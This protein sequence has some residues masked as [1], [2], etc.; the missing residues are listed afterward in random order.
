[1]IIAN[2]S[3]SQLYAKQTNEQVLKKLKRSAISVN[4]YLLNK[5][6]KFLEASHNEVKDMTYIAHYYTY[7]TTSKEAE[8]ANKKIYDF[9]NQI[10]YSTC[11]DKYS[12]ELMK[13]NN[14]SYQYDFMDEYGRLNGFLLNEK[15]CAM[16]EIKVK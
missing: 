12:R 8:K 14:V 2:L 15:K 11:S 1:L 13:N 10:I 16:L 3:I 7:L 4:T 9:Q 6:N 5:I